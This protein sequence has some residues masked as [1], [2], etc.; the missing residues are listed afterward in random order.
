MDLKKQLFENTR[1]AFGAYQYHVKHDG[2]DSA[3]AREWLHRFQALFGLI[4]TADLEDEYFEA[5]WKQ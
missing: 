5:T 4:L 1:L 2:E 3:E